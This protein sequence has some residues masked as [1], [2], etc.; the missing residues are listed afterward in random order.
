M[1]EKNSKSTKKPL[2]TQEVFE[3]LKA[4]FTDKTS[5]LDDFCKIMFKYDVT[6]S[7]EFDRTDMEN[8]CI[9]QHIIK[10]A[11]EIIDGLYLALTPE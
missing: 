1:V 9:P 3:K 8:F 4:H 10:V 6:Y 7:D 2:S 5:K 11:F